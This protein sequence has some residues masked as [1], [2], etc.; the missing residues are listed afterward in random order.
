[1]KLLGMV[2]IIQS[3]GSRRTQIRRHT[4]A[5]RLQT[6]DLW[7][8]SEVWDDRGEAGATVPGIPMNR[9]INKAIDVHTSKTLL[10]FIL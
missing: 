9:R 4:P 10:L 1:M 3:G 8:V 7:N 2:Q 5:P 6:L